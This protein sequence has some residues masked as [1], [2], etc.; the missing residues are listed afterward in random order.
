MLLTITIIDQDGFTQKD[1]FMTYT[2]IFVRFY[3]GR[4]CGRVYEIYRMIE[5]E[6]IYILTTKNVY[7]FDAHQIIEISTV[8][9]NVYIVSRDKDKVVFYINNYIDWDW[10]N[11]LY[12]PN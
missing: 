11:Q 12:Y 5:L 4:N 7:N 8:F 3:I 9:Y 1:K 6:K 10:F 2:K